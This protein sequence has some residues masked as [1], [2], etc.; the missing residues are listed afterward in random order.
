VA[1]ERGISLVEVLVSAIICALIATAVALALMAGADTDAD[2]RYRSQAAELAQ[3][4]QQRLKGLSALQLTDL[5]PPNQETR[6]VTLNGIPY[7][8]TST[9]NFLNST[10]GAACGSSG[11]GAAAYYQVISQVTW[12]INHRGPVTYASLITPPAGGT[13]LTDVEDQTGAP[14]PG[15]SVTATEQAADGSDTA[16]GTTDSSGCSI[17]SALDPGDYTLALSDPGYVT[18]DDVPADPYDLSAT[19]TSTGTA[20]PSGGNPIILGLA[21]T[22]NAS[23]NYVNGTTTTGQVA[24]AVSWYGAGTSDSMSNAEC[25]TSATSG[26]S[27]CPTTASSNITPAAT[28]PTSGSIT[29]FPFEF[30]GP[31]YTGNYSVWAGACKQE[32]P[33]TGYDTFTISPGSSQTLAVQ[34]PAL[35]LTVTYQGT[36]VAPTDVKMRFVSSS[37]TACSDP[38]SSTYITEPI[39]SDA[40]TDANGVLASPGQPF[41][42]TATSGATASASGKTGTWTICA[43]YK[44]NSLTTRKNTITGVQNNNMSGLNPATVAITSTST[45]GTC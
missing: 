26:A 28:V 15:V 11:A 31:S 24:P 9:A 33:P 16:S 40:A 42:S 25:E 20:T 2:Q 21:G 14:L 29:A 35:D 41:A 10:N 8:I 32:Q 27:T 37:G 7:Q 22:F 39:V 38:S 23:F 19:V 1:D 36:R 44:V 12:G 17:F 30:T 34:E 45:S 5:A 4:D 18:D 3:Q 13:L 43:D 6:T